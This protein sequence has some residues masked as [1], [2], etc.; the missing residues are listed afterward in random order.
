MKSTI[1]SE[2]SLKESV[3]S[4]DPSLATATDSSNT[5]KDWVTGYNLTLYVDFASVGISGLEPE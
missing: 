1:D 4:A 5:C 2:S 3:Y